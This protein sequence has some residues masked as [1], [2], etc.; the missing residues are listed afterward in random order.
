MNGW[1][2]RGR[3]VPVAELPDVPGEDGTGPFDARDAM[4]GALASLPPRQRAVLVLRYYDGLSEAEIA[5]A[6]GM[7]LQRAAAQYGANVIDVR[8]KRADLPDGGPLESA[9]Q[10]MRTDRLQEAAAIEASG[11]RDAQII[12]ADADAEASQTYAASF[13]KD[14]EFYDFYRAMQ[15]YQTTFVNNGQGGRMGA[16]SV[17][18]DPGSEYLRQFRGRA[19]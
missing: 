17:V 2:D 8:I 11:Q 15:S 9:F 18:M 3:E 12:R 7:R 10:R 14:A 19:Q 13:G 1:R 4:L 6:L 5:E 16:T